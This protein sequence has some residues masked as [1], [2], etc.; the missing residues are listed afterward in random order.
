MLDGK[1]LELVETPKR[2][3]GSPAAT[4]TSGRSQHSSTLG[5]IG[6]ASSSDSGGGGVTRRLRMSEARGSED[7]ANDGDT[8]NGVG[9]DADA[10]SE[11][12]HSNTVGGSPRQAGSEIDVAGGVEAADC[13]D[14]TDN[15]PPNDDLNGSISNLPPHPQMIE[16]GDT[17]AAA[18]LL[19]NGSV[20]PTFSDASSRVSSRKRTPS[21]VLADEDF[22]KGS[23][24]QVRFPLFW[25]F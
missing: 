18:K 11:H 4:E 16:T 6:A 5:T 14:E 1:T 24:P 15:L 8:S 12:A 10:G 21:R 9:E 19:R 7:G 2:S 13:R 25:Q 20:S 17:T 3:H 22:I 23:T